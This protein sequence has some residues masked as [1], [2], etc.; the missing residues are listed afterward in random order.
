M[1]SPTPLREQSS[2][3]PSGNK[4]NKALIVVVVIIG[5]LAALGVLARQFFGPKAIEQR[6]ERAIE[7]QTGG[8][9]NVD[10]GNEDDTLTIRTEEGTAQIGRDVVLPS[11]VPSYPGSTMIGGQAMTTAEG[12][13]GGFFSLTTTDAP[14]NVLT[15]YKNYFASRSWQQESELTMQGA[16]VVVFK[17]E[18][19]RTIS[20]SVGRQ[21][22]EAV[23]N[24]TIF[25][26]IDQ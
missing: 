16:T 13:Q 17:N 2:V 11:D 18:N 20:V 26:G 23:T 3:S 15:Y 24:I 7:Q 19:E 1:S 8:R 14:D 10:F 6:I 21:A 22:G 9:A 4:P 25:A 5:V 12:Q